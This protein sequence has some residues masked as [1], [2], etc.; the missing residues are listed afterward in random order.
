MYVWMT[1][2]KPQDLFNS[3]PSATITTSQLPPTT[4]NYRRTRTRRTLTTYDT[5]TGLWFYFILLVLNLQSISCYIAPSTS[6]IFDGGLVEAVPVLA[7][8]QTVLKSVKE[9][10]NAEYPK[11]MS[12]EG[13]S[14]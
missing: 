3:V 5:D 6:L 11:G 10:Q 9:A 7:N 14:H 2:D 8:C 12:W 13:E 1:D 4:A